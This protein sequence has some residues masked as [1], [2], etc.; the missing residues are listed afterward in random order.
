MTQE[1]FQSVIES[2]EDTPRI[3]HQLTNNLQGTAGTWKPSAEE[4]SVL[5]NVCHL[6]DLEREGYGVRIARLIKEDAPVMQDFD[7]ARAAKER[8]YNSLDLSE[9]LRDFTRAREEAMK[10]VRALST[11]QLDRSGT[12]EGAGKITLARLLLMMREHDES[13]LKDLRALRER[14]KSESELTA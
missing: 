2:L 14:L 5:E 13:H 3:V 12:L 9:A 1:E 6:A 7:G 4:F 11:E 8:D 10:T